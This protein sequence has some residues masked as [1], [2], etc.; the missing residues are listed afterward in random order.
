[1]SSSCDPQD[2]VHFTDWLIIM[3]LPSFFSFYHKGKEKAKQGADRIQIMNKELSYP[4]FPGKEKKMDGIIIRED[5]PLS[6][7]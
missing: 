3:K 7:I 2:S 1:M 6:F 4:S 5:E